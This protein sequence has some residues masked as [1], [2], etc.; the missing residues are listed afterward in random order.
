MST[1]VV[2]LFAGRLLVNIATPEP[3]VV[4][5]TVSDA[6]SMAV[7]PG[8][9]AG[10]G[11][12]VV[13]LRVVAGETSEPGAKLSFTELEIRDAATGKATTWGQ[14]RGVSPGEDGAEHYST[15]NV[16]VLGIFGPY[17]SL[18]HTSNG[19]EG[20]AHEYDDPSTTILH[21][22]GRAV[23]A[24]VLF[25][26]AVAAVGAAVQAAQL[27]DDPPEAT[28]ESLKSMAVRWTAETGLRLYGWLFCCTWVENHNQFEV[29]V[30][31]KVPAAWRAWLHGSRFEQPGGGAV[32]TLRDGFVHVQPGPKAKPVRVGRA[33]AGRV[34]GVS[35]VADKAPKLRGAAGAADP[36]AAWWG[37]EALGLC[38]QRGP[39]CV[40][41]TDADCAGR[42]VCVEHQGCSVHHGFCRSPKLPPPEGLS[43]PCAGTPRCTES[44]HCTRVG[45]RCLALSDADCKQ[46]TL[47]AAEGRCDAQFGF[48]VAS[49]ATCGAMKHCTEKQDGCTAVRGGCDVKELP[50]IYFQF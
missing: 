25:P 35:W 13:Q 11:A 41:R 27:E 5:V 10:D 49:D 8:Y 48:C 3:V 32:V 14:H 2:A 22:D 47:C 1:L 37:C 45:D 44:G 36:C 50:F 17:I 24:T 18:Q 16:R 29:D 23:D 12:R 33:P 42:W 20:G 34:V 9:A 30:P 15:Q 40:A 26:D 38:H 43:G 28:R 19:W 46:A 4:D 7:H 21:V 6:P 31:L 39:T